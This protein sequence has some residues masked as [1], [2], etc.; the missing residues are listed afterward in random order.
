MC[1]FM[2]LPPSMLDTILL[3]YF[4]FLNNLGLLDG[5]TMHGDDPTIIFVV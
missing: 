1:V 2:K 4:K 5:R 3:G